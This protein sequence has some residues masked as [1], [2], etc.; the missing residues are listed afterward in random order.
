MKYCSHCDAPLVMEGNSDLLCRHCAQDLEKAFEPEEEGAG[1]GPGGFERKPAPRYERSWATTEIA[2]I[3]EVATVTK[4]SKP[5]KGPL[6]IGR[7]RS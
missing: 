3:E 4:K 2:S 7:R 1:D 5:G 6:R